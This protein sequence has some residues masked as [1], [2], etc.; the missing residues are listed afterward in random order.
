MR[1][2]APTVTTG[3]TTLASSGAMQ[4]DDSQRGDWQRD[5]N[6]LGLGPRRVTRSRR[7]ASN[8]SISPRASCANS[9]PAGCP[10]PGRDSSD[11]LTVL[12]TVAGHLRAR[13]HRAN[14][15]AHRECG[16][17]IAPVQAANRSS[18][19][20]A[21]DRCT[22]G[23]GLQ[24]RS[25]GLLAPV[26]SGGALCS[27]SCW[28]RCPWACPTSPRPSPSASAVSMPGPGCASGWRSGY[29]RACAQHRQ[30]R[31]RLRAR[32]I[33]RRPAYRGGRHRRG[34]RRHGS[35]RDRTR[36]PCRHQDRRAG[37]GSR[38]RR[39]A[40]CRHRHRGRAPLNGVEGDHIR[41]S[42]AATAIRARELNAVGPVPEER[43]RGLAL[44]RQ[45]E[46]PD[47]ANCTWARGERRSSL[48]TSGSAREFWP[49]R[50]A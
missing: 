32:H 50:G 21:A 24:A 16:N 12:Y 9:A 26:S 2:S 34:Q 17:P 38:R 46:T 43:S 29:L 40:R 19:H 41:L 23:Q 20:E 45:H 36:P 44:L 33:S 27:R 11:P 39:P 7:S 28:W 3:D 47:D 31:C 35:H 1:F 37:R 14:R 30:P 42:A 25:R 18:R 8:C 5:T 22:A 13:A 4:R 6:Q 49:M 48:M 15:V 10:G